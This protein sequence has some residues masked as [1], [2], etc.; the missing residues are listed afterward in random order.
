MGELY[1]L[2]IGVGLVVLGMWFQ[3][4]ARDSLRPDIDYNRL[5]RFLY[6]RMPPFDHLTKKGQDCAIKAYILFFIGLAVIAI[7]VF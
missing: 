4:K 1:C 7:S 3:N 5:Q 2:F 6:S